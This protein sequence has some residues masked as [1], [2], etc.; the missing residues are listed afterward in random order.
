M[1]Q[2]FSCASLI[3]RMVSRITAWS[4]QYVSTVQFLF[5]HTIVTPCA[6][7]AHSIF[8]QPIYNLQFIIKSFIHCHSTMICMQL[9]GHRIR[10]VS[11]TT[12]TSR[13]AIRKFPAE[14]P[15]EEPELDLPVASFH[16]TLSCGMPEFI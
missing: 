9:V 13:R 1:P 8:H 7:Y 15:V 10:V 3:F 14:E 4:R 6:P 2:C 16:C 11:T 5:L 12:T